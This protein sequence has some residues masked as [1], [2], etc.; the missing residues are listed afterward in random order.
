M[1]RYD[2]IGRSS[3]IGGGAILSHTAS[4]CIAIGIQFLRTPMC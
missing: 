1:L 4:T 2:F 3:S